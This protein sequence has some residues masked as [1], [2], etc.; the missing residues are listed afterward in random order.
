MR[1]DFN[2]RQQQEEE[3][4]VG[5]GSSVNMPHKAPIKYPH[6]P[7]SLSWPSP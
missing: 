6:T 4:E 3:E 7:L 2:Q 5:K 1:Q